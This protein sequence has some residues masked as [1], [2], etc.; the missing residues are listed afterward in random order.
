[1][2]SGHMSIGWRPQRMY[3][4]TSDWCVRA[5]HVLQVLR[6]PSPCS[7]QCTSQPLTLLLYVDVGPSAT[8]TVHAD[9]NVTTE[10]NELGGAG[11]EGEGGQ[12]GGGAYT[13]RASILGM[14]VWVSG[15]T[16]N[17]ATRAA[18]SWP[19]HTGVGL[20]CSGPQPTGRRLATSCWM[21][22]IQ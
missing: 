17:A 10:R 1:M 13:K 6:P 12:Q 16:C 19:Q 5:V 9:G 15:D 3:G 22:S 20:P 14:D 2:S 4:P 8:I 18:L 21:R 7:R 11:G